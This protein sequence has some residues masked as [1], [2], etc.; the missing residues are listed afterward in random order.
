MTLK[1]RFALAF[2]AVAGLAIGLVIALSF[3]AISSLL[4]VDTDQTFRTLVDSVT[5]RATGTQLDPDSFASATDR[6][7]VEYQVL[8]SRQVVA[9]VLGPGGDLAVADPARQALPVGAAE[10]RLA[11]HPIAGE[12]AERSFTGDDG[13]YELVTVALGGGRGAVQIAQPTA[14]TDHLLGQLIELMLIVG[15]CVFVAAGV[16]GWLVAGRLTRRLQHLTGVAEEVARSGRLN[17]AVEIRGRD[18]V[19]RLGS[20]FD[21]M[22][23]QLAEARADQ[24]RLVE[25]AGHE[26]RTPLTSVRTNV[27]VLRRRGDG[28]TAEARDRIL[29]DLDEETRELATLTNELVELAIGEYAGAAAEDCSLVALAERVGERARRRTGRAIV[30]TA[31]RGDAVA[32]VRRVGIERALA[33]LVDNAAKFDPGGTAPI[34]IRVRAD[35]IAVLDQGPGLE[36]EDLPRI[37]DRFY[38]SAAARA[39]PGSGLGLAIVRQVA[40]AHGGTV[41][42]E[43]RP[44]G[45]AIIG[46]TLATE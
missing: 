37:F 18:E 12:Q 1:T 9:Q 17:A 20:A 29:D 15:G 3:D 28:L 26:L 36:P 19:G 46:F 38:R 14:E 27:T 22:L 41:F 10:R 40:E 7:S 33:N 5:I 11:A 2:A 42:A 35:R 44:A 43:N 39:L 45:G 8:N 21:T 34:Q 16:T 30:V 4:R 31:D 32:R 24:R 13:R 23:G 25:D 6:R